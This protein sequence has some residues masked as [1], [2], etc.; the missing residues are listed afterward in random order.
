VVVDG[1]G[2]PSLAVP[3]A[4]ER[5]PPVRQ[6]LLR[7]RRGRRYEVGRADAARDPADG[8]RVGQAP[9]QTVR[10]NPQ[11]LVGVAGVDAG[12]VEV[13]ADVGA[14]QSERAGRGDG[15]RCP[16][17]AAQVQGYRRIG[18]AGRAAVV[19][20]EAERQRAVGHGVH[21]VGEPHVRIPLAR[22]QGA[23]RRRHG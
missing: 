23:E 5:P 7:G 14:S 17:G 9:A 18:R 2:V 1:L 3:Q 19:G 12:D 16:A 8:A 11:E 15:V 4:L 22:P 21:D 20:R 10:Q 13:A 6:R